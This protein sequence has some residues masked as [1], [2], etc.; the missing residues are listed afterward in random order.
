MTVDRRVT[1]SANDVESLDLHDVLTSGWVAEETSESKVDEK[2]LARPVTGTYH[3]I[4]W[5]NIKMNVMVI[6][7]GL[8]N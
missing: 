7:Q 3:K 5:F 2:D 8:E 6:M 4:V 1:E